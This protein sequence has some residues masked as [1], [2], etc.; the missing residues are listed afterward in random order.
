MR[1]RPVSHARPVGRRLRGE[2]WAALFYCQ[3]LPGA[4]QRQ[5][6]RRQASTSPVPAAGSKLLPRAT[7]AWLSP[8]CTGQ[9]HKPG[10][11]RSRSKLRERC[12]GRAAD[13]TGN[14]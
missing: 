2:R 5:H 7:W 11:S 4:V 6:S 1:V 8:D 13:L 10:P 14:E 9:Q 3:V 12:A